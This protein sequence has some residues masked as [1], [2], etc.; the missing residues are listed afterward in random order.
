LTAV[1]VGSAVVVPV[2]LLAVGAAV[3]VVVVA[4]VVT[5]GVV[6]AVVEVL[7]VVF[8]P[9][10]GI[11]TRSTANKTIIYFKGASVLYAGFFYILIVYDF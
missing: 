6:V 2:G 4:V 10:D 11:S 5:A 3:V 7:V 1:A 8:S 9:Q